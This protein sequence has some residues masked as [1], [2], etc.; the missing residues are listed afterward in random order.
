MTK[1]NKNLTECCVFL[2]LLCLLFARCYRILSFKSTNNGGRLQNYYDI[3]VPLDVIVYGSSHA[4]CAVNNA[5]LWED[6]GISSYTL[7]VANQS[8]DGILYFME[9]SFRINKPQAALI[10]T[11]TFVHEAEGEDSYDRTNLTGPWSPGY[12]RYLLKQA[13]RMG[14]DRQKTQEYL[15][16]MPIVHSRYNDLSRD[17]FITPYPYMR[18]YW[19]SKLTEQIGTPEPTER[20][21]ELP[22]F[23]RLCLEQMVRLC[24]DNGVLPVFFNAPYQ[25]S[26]EDMAV[27]NTIGDILSG[28][29]VTYINFNKDAARYGIDYA[30]D[31]REWSHMNDSG[32]AKVTQVLEDIL[33]EQIDPG[34]HRGETGYEMWDLHARFL[35]DK[36]D[37]A[38]LESAPEL[39]EYLTALDGMK[40][41][42]LI[43]LS[44][45]GNY[46][47]L[48]DE[49]FRVQIE[50]LCG[51]TAYYENGGILVLDGGKPVC[52]LPGEGACVWQ[53]R[54]A[55][56]AELTVYRDPEETWPHVLLEDKE[57]T[58]E[59]NGVNLLVYDRECAEIVDRVCVNVYEGLGTIRHE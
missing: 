38:R 15:L 25:T 4:G 16:R 55:D 36:E 23:N 32:A 11:Y 26:E 19:G 3:R 2:V 39:P 48:G 1:R 33:R 47:A 9:E 13:A 52:T 6:A 18:G 40:E 59:V 56:H 17:D 41:R 12:V 24:R 7:G 45:Q 35:A 46:R 22:E 20:R 37:T 54:A 31:M 51:E 49:A 27:Q 50:N 10:E 21:Q 53:I 34:D 5:M 14:Y 8:I 44:L 58:E 28:E 29:N 43:V 57:Y 42:Y 30:T